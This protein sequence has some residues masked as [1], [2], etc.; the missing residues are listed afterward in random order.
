MCPRSCSWDGTR[1]ASALGFQVQ[2]Q[3]FFQGHLYFTLSPPSTH[4][5]GYDFAAFR[6]SCCQDH[7][8]ARGWSGLQGWL[9]GRGEGVDVVWGK[10]GTS[11]VHRTK[12]PSECPFHESLLA[13]ASRDP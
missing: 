8:S 11:C 9:E 13:R 1:L 3:G 6:P 10:L 5:S 2:V 7:C 4:L 12:Q